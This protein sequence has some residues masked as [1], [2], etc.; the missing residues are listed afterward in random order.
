MHAIRFWFYPYHNEGFNHWVVKIANFIP[1]VSKFGDK[2]KIL[3]K[4][5]LRNEL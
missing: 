4:E 1:T 2:D 5:V 3:K